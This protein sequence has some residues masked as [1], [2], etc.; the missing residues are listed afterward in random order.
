MCTKNGSYCEKKKKSGGGLGVD[1][2]G[3]VRLLRKCKKKRFFFFFWGGGV[4]FG[5]GEGLGGGEG[6][7]G[8]ELRSEAFVKIKKKN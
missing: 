2:N 1:V 3:E 5:G 8:C 6:Q 7:G 4:G